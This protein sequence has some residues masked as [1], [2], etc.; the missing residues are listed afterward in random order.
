MRKGKSKPSMKF[1]ALFRQISRT[2]R[3]KRRDRFRGEMAFQI[4]ACLKM[5]IFFLLSLSLGLISCERAGKAVIS[6]GED[7]ERVVLRVREME[8]DEVYR[9]L[10]QRSFPEEY[11]ELVRET[12]KRK[13]GSHDPFAE[14][15]TIPDGELTPSAM[16]MDEWG[17]ALPSRVFEKLGFPIFDIEDGVL[18]DEGR[19]VTWDYQ[20]GIIEIRHSARAIAA[21]RERFPEFEDVG[22]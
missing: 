13:E 18:V 5:R 11:E 3:P 4:C 1:R 15:I 10:W 17:K 14:P 8:A 21:F 20:T 19:S 22:E 16:G 2:G 12:E 7:M 6:S 9:L